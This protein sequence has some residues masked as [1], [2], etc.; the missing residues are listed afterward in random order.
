MSDA[1]RRSKGYVYTVGLGPQ[2]LASSND[3]YQNIYDS[4]SRKE[5]FLRRVAY[6][7]YHAL[8]LSDP[9]LGPRRDIVVNDP[10]DARVG[11][12]IAMGYDGYQPYMSLA[13]DPAYVES[14]GSYSGTSNA[15][16]LSRTFTRLAKQILLRLVG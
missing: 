9:Q 12:T 6:D 11:Q 4:S 2:S 5:Y 3:P 13:T 1:I 10:G 16:E 7:F 15:A 8:L 14:A